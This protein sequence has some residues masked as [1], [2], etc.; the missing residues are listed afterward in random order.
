MK[1]GDMPYRDVLDLKISDAQGMVNSCIEERKFADAAEGLPELH[2]L[3]IER[4][5]VEYVDGVVDN[6]KI[7]SGERLDSYLEHLVYS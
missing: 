3:L 6:F 1:Y 7:A 2:D 5:E 4:Q